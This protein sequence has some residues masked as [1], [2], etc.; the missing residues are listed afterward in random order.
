MGIGV[1]SIF[2]SQFSISYLF[3]SGLGK[4]IKWM[5]MASKSE[6]K[7]MIDLILKA[8]NGDHGAQVDLGLLI[9]SGAAVPCDL[10]EHLKW[11]RRAARKGIRE[12][13]RYLG[14]LYSIESGLLVPYNPYKAFRWYER[15]ALR[16][17]P[18][19]RLEVGKMY[20]MGLGVTRDRNEALKW[21]L[22][23]RNKADVEQL[24][25]LGQILSDGAFI[26][27]K[28]D[29]AASCFRKAAEQGNYRAVLFLAQFLLEEDGHSREGWGEEA[30]NPDNRDAILSKLELLVEEGIPSAHY[31]IQALKEWHEVEGGDFGK[32]KKAAEAGNPMAQLRVG[33]MLRMGDGIAKDEGEAARWYREAAE[34]GDPLAQN[35]LGTMYALGQGISQDLRKAAFWFRQASLQGYATAMSNLGVLYQ[36]GHGVPQSQSEAARWFEIAAGE[37]NQEAMKELGRMLIHGIGVEK[38]PHRGVSL[39]RE[40]AESGYPSAQSALGYICFMG[41]G[42]PADPGEAEMWFRS[43]SA[44]GDEQGLQ[45]LVEMMENNLTEKTDVS[46]LVMWLFDA[47]LNCVRENS[48]ETA[49]QYLLAIKRVSPGNFL[50]KRLEGEIKKG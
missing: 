37:G 40:A 32:L 43:A 47:G 34:R 39:L 36:R 42:V 10:A 31:V 3:A 22:K 2:Y 6:R 35:Q 19:A 12:A 1:F 49:F 45:N 50:E 20:A 14:Y 27:P 21:F 17:D 23:A 38:D 29:V 28:R 9:S 46:E 30:L 41:E 8:R 25:V 24:T 44:Q 16:G 33:E 4:C 15:A 48:L 18:E 7:R 11:T 26:P 13:Q 5:L